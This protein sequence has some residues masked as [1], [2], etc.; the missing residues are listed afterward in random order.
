MSRSEQ[1]WE[2]AKV[3]GVCQIASLFLPTWIVALPMG[4]WFDSIYSGHAELHWWANQPE[5]VGLFFVICNSIGATLIF[6]MFLIA[7]ARGNA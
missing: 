6:I 7:I 3:F 5:L 1:M 2:V 4:A